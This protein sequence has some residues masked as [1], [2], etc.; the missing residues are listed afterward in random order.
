MTSAILYKQASLLAFDKI[1]YIAPN[2]RLEPLETAT[3]DRHLAEFHQIDVE[4]AR[5]PAARTRW[6]WPRAWSARSWSTGARRCPAELDAARPGP[7]RRCASL[8]PEPFDR[9]H[10]PRGHR[11]TA[12]PS[13]TPQNRGR[14]DRLAGRGAAV[15][16][17]P[18]RPFFVTDYPKGSRGFYDRETPDRPGVLR[19]FDLIAARGL[20]RAVQRQRAG[21]RLRAAR[22]ADAGDRREPGQVRLVPRPGPRAASRPAPASASA[23]SGFTRYVAG[24][25]RR[26]AGQRLPEAARGGL[27]VT[28]ALRAGGFPERP[29]TATGPGAA[30][31]AAFPAR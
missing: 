2:V 25:R 24:L 28:A 11:R 14:R 3:T 27:A 7:R 8:L 30:R 12:S 9:A 21:V 20:R 29:G 10:P 6:R 15:R 17:A 4:V 18:T 22:H 31:P 5:A 26:L 23:W 16:S 13:A 1:F 19:N